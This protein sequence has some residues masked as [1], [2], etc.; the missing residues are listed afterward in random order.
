[1]HEGRLSALFREI[2]LQ[3]FNRAVEINFNQSK[4]YEPGIPGI[5]TA[6]IAPRTEVLDILPAQINRV[7]G[8]GQNGRPQQACTESVMS[9]R[10]EDLG[11]IALKI[12]ACRYINLVT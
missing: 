12:R 11:S 7:N 1:M 3:T 2:H 5:E 10:R 4:S 8:I 6:P 9:A